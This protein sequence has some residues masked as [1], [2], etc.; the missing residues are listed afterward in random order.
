MQ[1]INGIENKEIEAL[2]TGIAI[3]LL[4]LL[5]KAIKGWWDKRLADKKEELDEQ[6]IDID[7]HSADEKLYHEGL[8][9]TA[10]AA[11]QMSTILTDVIDPL[12][13]RV[14]I[15]EEDA[16]KNLIEIRGLRDEIYNLEHVIRLKD[17]ELEDL[18][19]EY[20]KQ[21]AVINSQEVKISAQEVRI[22]ELECELIK[23]K[24]DKGQ[25]NGN[26]Y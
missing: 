1:I 3:P 16:K 18:K 26:S 2:L 19:K 24:K 13:N 8:K 10:D 6:K 17:T 23:M 22:A 11:K 12:V 21:L 4:Y 7:H 9:S 20:N 15:L 5:G 14:K 25:C